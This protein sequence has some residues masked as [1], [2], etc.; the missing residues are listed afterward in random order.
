MIIYDYIYIYMCMYICIYTHAHAIYTYAMC[1]FFLL[2]LSVGCNFPCPVS[3]P[4]VMF[5]GNS[6]HEAWG[7]T[8]WAGDGGVCVAVSFMVSMFHSF[9]Q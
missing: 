8:T 6:A 9:L 1:R 4:Q 2:S 3:L 7:T 5:N